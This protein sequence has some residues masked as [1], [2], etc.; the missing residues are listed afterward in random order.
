MEALKS[1]TVVRK[2]IFK[3]FKLNESTTMCLCNNGCECLP[4]I[5]G[6]LHCSNQY[7]KTTME[8]MSLILKYFME[9]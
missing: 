4:K 2:N 3:L 5:F 8:I 9:K 1:F 7:F 6:N